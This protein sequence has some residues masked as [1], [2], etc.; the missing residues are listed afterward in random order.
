MEALKKNYI[1]HHPGA[2]GKHLQLKLEMSPMMAG[3]VT[4]TR[5]SP[6]GLAIQANLQKRW[7]R[8]ANKKRPNSG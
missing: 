8:P 6:G 2:S 5:L 7:C 4:C 1:D 3:Q